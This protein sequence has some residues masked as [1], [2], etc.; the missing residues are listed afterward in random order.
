VGGL[1]LGV[2]GLA[3]NLAVLAA[4]TLLRPR[5]GGRSVVAAVT[6]AEA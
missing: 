6:A 5:I 1:T 4:V 2:I 3:A